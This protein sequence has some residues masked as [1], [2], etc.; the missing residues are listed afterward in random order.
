MEHKLRINAESVVQ[1]EA[2]GIIF[3]VHCELLAQLDEH[4]VEPTQDVWAIVD[5][6][7]EDSNTGHE[8]SSCLLIEAFRYGRAVGFC[9]RSRKS[10]NAHSELSRGVL[11]M[12]DK[13]DG[14]ARVGLHLL[15]SRRD[16]FKVGSERCFG[17]DGAHFPC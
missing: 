7:L 10:G 14:A 17:C 9:E 4:A 16:D 12:R 8:D 13:L 15:T 3:V 11:V 2:G 6:S 5:L 1:C